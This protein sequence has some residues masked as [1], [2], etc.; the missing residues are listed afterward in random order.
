MAI[1]REVRAFFDPAVFNASPDAAR[2]SRKPIRPQNCPARRRGGLPRAVAA[3][4]ANDRA[5]P[6]SPAPKAECLLP[7]PRKLRKK[8]VHVSSQIRAGVR[9]VRD[10][11][12]R[13]VWWQ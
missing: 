12:W 1:E 11:W 5:R 2:R 6:P 8:A 9:G 7:W 13:R 4:L 10:R 3:A